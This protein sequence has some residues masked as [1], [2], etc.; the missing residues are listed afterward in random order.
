MNKFFY[1]IFS[2]CRCLDIVYPKRLP[3]VTVIIVF[4]NEA[5]SALTRTLWSVINTTP[6]AL[7]KEIILV[8]DFST[9][10]VR[11]YRI[12]DYINTL[13]VPTI[14][15]RTPARVGLIQARLLGASKAIVSFPYPIYCKN[16]RIKPKFV[17]TG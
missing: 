12:Q 16:Q 2:L 8:D 1:E 6:R 4:H 11:D 10:D 3:E 13:P 17:H 14:Q 5:W 9:N 7:L 15:Y